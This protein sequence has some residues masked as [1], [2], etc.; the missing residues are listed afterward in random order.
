MNPT[1]WLAVL[2][3]VFVLTGPALG[4]TKHSGTTST[5]NTVDQC[6]DLAEQLQ[7]GGLAVVLQ[8]GD[9]ARALGFD[10]EQFMLAQD[11]I[12]SYQSLVQMWV[13]LDPG[14]ISPQ[15][16]QAMIMIRFIMD[17]ELF[18]ILTPEQ[19]QKLEALYQQNHG[20]DTTQVTQTVPVG[21][22]KATSKK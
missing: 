10:E 22:A 4:Q 19:Q 21:G 1:R 5:S 6:A 15:T 12:E 2:T 7:F 18:S 17:M 13:L 3:L 11:I 14:M 16:M 9:L 20:T 8:D